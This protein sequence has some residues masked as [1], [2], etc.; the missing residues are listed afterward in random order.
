MVYVWLTLAI[1]AEVVATTALKAT[2]EFTNLVPS[3]VCVAGYAVAFYLLT[4][5]LRTMPVGIAYAI[6]SGLGIV[7]V[8]VLGALTYRQIPDAAAIA[9]MALIIAGTV[10]INVFSNTATH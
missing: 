1:C 8:G 9:G 2:N 4:L 10:V 7:L 3:L 6:W 5:V